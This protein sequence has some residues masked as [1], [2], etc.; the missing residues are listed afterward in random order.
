MISTLRTAPVLLLLA[1]IGLS[2]PAHAQATFERIKSRSQISVG[3]REDAAPFSYLDDQ[4]KAIGYSIDFCAA[5]VA[6][7]ANRLDLK[8]LRIN[9]VPIAIDRVMT[10]VR[11][12]SVDLLCTGTSDTPERRALASF[13]KP[14]YFDGVGVMVRKKDGITSLKQL[15]GKQV[16]FIKAST[17]GSALDAYRAKA[18]ISW[19]AEPGLNADA[20]F[21]Q[22]QLGWVQAY[23]RD[24][25]LL[26]MQLASLSDADQY[27][28]LPERLS[29]EAI[30][31]A[32]RKDDGEMQALVDGV[33][34]ELAV[35]GKARALHDKWFVGP[36][37]LYKQRKALG[38]PMSPELKASLETK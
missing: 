36:I 1:C 5:V 31:I 21:S 4:K 29:T 28:I 19:K 23:A 27:L 35:S 18:A 22:L 7:L 11:D 16:S 13:S 14:I 12:G 10:F 6:Q 8:N 32:F 25:V 3:Y 2:A 38:I 37:P 20:A 9:M 17:A 34:A 24:K 15:D 33:I 26:A 30:A